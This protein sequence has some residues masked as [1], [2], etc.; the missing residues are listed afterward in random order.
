MKKVKPV[1]GLAVQVGLYGQF[2]RTVG[3]G[4]VLHGNVNGEQQF[5][6]ATVG[7]TLGKLR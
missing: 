2:G 6:G 3:C 4:L 7:L 1:V 5:A